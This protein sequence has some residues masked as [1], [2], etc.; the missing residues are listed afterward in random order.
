MLIFAIAAVIT[1]A[2]IIE[3]F[4]V[5]RGFISTYLAPVAIVGLLVLAFWPDSSKGRGRGR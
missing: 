2:W 5:G 3:S 1:I 4:T